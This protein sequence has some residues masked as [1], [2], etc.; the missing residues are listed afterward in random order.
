MI[1]SLGW[2][3]G[4]LTL[5][6]YRSKRNPKNGAWYIQSLCHE[7]K[8]HAFTKDLQDMLTAV[9][10]RVSFEYT[11]ESKE[12][13]RNNNKITPYFETRLTRKVQ[14]EPPGVNRKLEESDVNNNI[15]I[16]NN[17]QDIE[18]QNIKE[19]LSLLQVVTEEPNDSAT[20][21]NNNNIKLEDIEL[22]NI[23]EKLS[24]LQVVTEEPKDSASDAN[25]HQKPWL[26]IYIPSRAND[27]TETSSNHELFPILEQL[28]LVTFLCV[29]VWTSDLSAYCLFSLRIE[30]CDL[31]VC[32]VWTSDLS[33]YCLFSLRIETCD[34]PVCAVWTS[35]LSAYCLFSLRIETCDLPVCARV[36]IRSQRLLSL[37]FEN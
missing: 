16:T 30:T 17:E 28:R 33:A 29:P 23:M 21:V 4:I 36:D 8:Q 13:S 37:L 3:V 12:P 7:L 35:D 2:S 27:Q 14:F 32:A 31:P 19:K 9:H 15:D 20:D 34:L 26:I 1:V 6:S 22:Q 25:E 5:F 11:S 18:L 24:S 10:R